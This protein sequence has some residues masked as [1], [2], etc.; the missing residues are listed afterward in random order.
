MPI[1]K[2]LHFH[3]FKNGGSTFDWILKH[4]FGNQFA[5]F[6]GPTAQDSLLEA[7]I[8]EFLNK[9]PDLKAHINHFIL[10]F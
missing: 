7:D 9:S 2:I 6:H 10:A 4:N 1:L 3:T 5:E 8:L